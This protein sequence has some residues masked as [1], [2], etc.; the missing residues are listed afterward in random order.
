MGRDTDAIGLF[1]ESLS[2]GPATSDKYAQFA[3]VLLLT[4]HR[5]EAEEMARKAVALD[6]KS[7]SNHEVLAVILLSLGKREEAERERKLADQLPSSH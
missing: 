7:S 6:S 5:N 1:R 2:H 4:H 3:R